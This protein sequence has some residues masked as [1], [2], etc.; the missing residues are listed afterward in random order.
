MKEETT[1]TMDILLIFLYIIGAY[2]F[3][4]GMS[5]A[6]V[7]VLFPKLDEEGST[8]TAPSHWH[9]LRRLT[10][11]NVNVSQRIKRMTEK[12]YRKMPYPFSN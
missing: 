10:G 7:K 12:R 3:F 9:Q 4:L 8:S 5:Y 6:L 2:I 11:M 1:I